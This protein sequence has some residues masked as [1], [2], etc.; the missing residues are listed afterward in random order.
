MVSPNSKSFWGNFWC[1][2]SCRR[3]Y[4]GPARHVCFCKIFIIDYTVF[5]KPTLIVGYHEETR[6]R[7]RTVKS[8]FNE[9]ST[10]QLGNRVGRGGRFPA[11]FHP[12][13]YSRD[14]TQESIPR[15][16]FRQPMQPGGR[17]RQPYSYFGVWTEI[18]DVNGFYTTL[19][20]RCIF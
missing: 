18:D 16:R 2:A 9:I 15:N 12:F 3:Q 8:S 17:V 6:R 4:R 13:L 10:D 11:R 5:H 19:N 1:M 20:I 7:W 14:V